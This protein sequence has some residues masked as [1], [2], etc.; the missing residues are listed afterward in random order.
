M[1]R[2]TVQTQ[3]KKRKCQSIHRN[4]YVRLSI[5]FCSNIIFGNTYARLSIVFCSYIIFEYV[6]HKYRCFFHVVI[7]GLKDKGK[8]FI[9]YMKNLFIFFTRLCRNDN[10]LSGQKCFSW[11]QISYLKSF[12]WVLY[13][14]FPSSS[15]GIIFKTFCFSA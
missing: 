4:T 7:I 12:L 6:S 2:T 5:V 8:I 13:K 3:C 10:G 1:S 11:N 14:L 15:F 9:H